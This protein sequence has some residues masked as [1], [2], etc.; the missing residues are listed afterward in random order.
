MRAHEKE[1]TM[2]ANLMHATA[3][4]GL[5]LL[6]T[7]LRTGDLSRVRLSDDLIGMKVLSPAGESLG[8]IEDIVVHPG[9]IPSYAVLSFG[10][11]LGMGDKLFALPWS[12]LREAQPKHDRTDEAE[13]LELPLDKERLKV[14][15]GFDKKAWPKLAN[16]DWRKDIDAF[17]LGEARAEPK[18]AVQGAA[19]LSILAWKVS[20]LKGREVG[21]LEG[22]KLGDIEEVALDGNGRVT[23]VALSVGGFLGM[24]ERLT[25]VPWDSLKFSLGGEKGD[26][27]VITLAQ[28][29]E[30]IAKAPEFHHSRQHEAEM[31]DPL[32]ITALYD[33]Y[34]CP[35]YWKEPAVV[36]APTSSQR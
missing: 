33:F 21:T 13:A 30:K 11:W 10:G 34:S 20:E 22:E 1:L 19:P 8:K 16:P 5:A 32:W 2:K 31:R 9:G 7:S 17:Y 27:M 3:F 6:S 36:R 23:Y 25:A 15:P 26:E 29:K 18:P 14:A 28:T 24:G 4:A 12:A 35:H